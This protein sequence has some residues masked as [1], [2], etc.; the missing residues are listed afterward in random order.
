MGFTVNTSGCLFS[1]K[2]TA[3]EITWNRTILMENEMLD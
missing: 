3:N 2:Y 1:Y